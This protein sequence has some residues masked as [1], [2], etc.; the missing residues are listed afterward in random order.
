[1]AVLRA[2]P[3]GVAD[4]ADG[5]KVGYVT[6]DGASV[7]VPVTE[8]WGLALEMAQPARRFTSYKGQRNLPGRWWS[9]TDGR[10]VGYE[11]WLER[12][13]LM[14]LDFDPAVMGIA[15]RPFWLSWVTEER[16]RRSHAPDYFARK[17]DGSGVVIDCR[18]AERRKPRGMAA[19]E[20]TR[21]ACETVGWE[22]RLVGGPDP[23]TTANVRWLAGY[24]HPPQPPVNA[25]LPAA[26]RGYRPRHE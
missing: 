2:A 10:R 17:A 26:R 9:A 22:Y 19:F 1:M 8:A 11:S 23:T 4:S 6:E 15:S 21:T 3:G 13:H 12:D 7:R 25:I 18:P 16:K 20:A 24:R 14:L 5:L